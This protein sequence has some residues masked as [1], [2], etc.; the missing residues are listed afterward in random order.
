MKKFI[1]IF[2]FL[3]LTF[4]C[5]KEIDR[6]SIVDLVK[7]NQYY[8]NE[9]FNSQNLKI[10]GKWQLLYTNGG[11]GGSTIYPEHDYS[12]EFERFGIYGKITDN[13]IKEIGKIVI[14][15]QDNIETIINFLPDDK[16]KTDSYLIQKVVVF[17]G[18][19]TLVLCDNMFDGYNNIYKRIK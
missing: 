19:D 13:Q 17:K 1:W 6:I 16:Y 10:Y 18:T 9:V 12:I 4:S 2:G 11:F 14:T 15:K 5:E 8:E 3:F 7:Q